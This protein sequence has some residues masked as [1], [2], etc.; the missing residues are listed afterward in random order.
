M[1]IYLKIAGII[2][3]VLGI[4][5]VA[6]P[7]RFNWKT[8]LAGLSLINRQM[9]VVH[10]FFIALT[11]FMMGILSL[12]YSVQLLTNPFGKVISMGLAIF[13]FIRL[14]FQF[15]VYS[16][17]LWRGKK[18]ETIMHIIFALIWIYLTVVYFMT[19]RAS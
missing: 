11:V 6:F 5:H 4:V 16:K 7:R 18:F 2:L 12:F 9:M 17:E 19:S 1:E 3:I 10:T 14:V 8:D 13:W 15:F